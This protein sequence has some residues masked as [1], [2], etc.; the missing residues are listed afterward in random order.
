MNKNLF[1]KNLKAYRE[2]LGLTLYAIS[3]NT[4]LSRSVLGYYERGVKNPSLYNLLILANFFEFTLND[5]CTE[6]FLPFTKEDKE[7][8]LA[9]L[10]KNE[11]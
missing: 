1:P 2:D 11:K 9:K 5:L 8:V 7:K 4:G 10:N 3:K 6:P